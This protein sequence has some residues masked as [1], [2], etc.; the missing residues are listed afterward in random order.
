M[1]RTITI[2]DIAHVA[3]TI[4]PK[5]AKVWLYGSRARGDARS[6]S[7]WDILVLID[8]DTKIASD[9]FK[10]YGYPI[11]E[12]GWQFGADIS[13]HIYTKKDWEQMRITPYYQN[14][15]R[16]KRIIYES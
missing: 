11:I 13:P 10:K 3:Q 4:M 9:D 15:E 6:D 2:S 12:Y 1:A 14:I 7:D 16:D 8:K 5:G